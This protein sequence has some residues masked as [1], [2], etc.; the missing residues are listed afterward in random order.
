MADQPGTGQPA[1][2]PADVTRAFSSI[3]ERTHETLREWTARNAYHLTRMGFQ[4]PLSFTNA[5]F[6]VTASMIVDPTTVVRAHMSLWRDYMG[7]WQQTAS[8]LMGYDPEA[9]DATDTVDRRFRDDVWKDNEIFL[10]VKQSYLLAARWLLRIIR[11]VDG[12]DEAT[13]QRAD[14]YAR[15][16]VNA[17]SPSRFVL[18][19]P[20][21]IRA[22]IDSGGENLL[23]SLRHVLDDLERSASIGLRFDVSRGNR[24]GVDI[25]ASAGAVVLRTPVME[26]IQ[27][28]ARTPRV[29]GRPLLF[30][31]P[32]IHK[33]YVIDLR[34]E[35]SWI[36]WAVDQG[37][38]V[39]VISWVNPDAGRAGLTF[40]DYLRDGA[41][42]AFDAVA[43][44]TGQSAINVIGYCLGGTL[45]ATAAAVRSSGRKARVASLSLLA[46]LTDYAEPGELGVF[47]DEAT[48]RYFET[49]AEAGHCVDEHEA[50]A[51]YKMLRATDLIWSFIFNNYIFGHDAF[52]DDLLAWN[53]DATRIPA[54]LHADYLCQFYQRN[55]LALP[56]GLNVADQ[57]I[58][59]ADIR[60]PIYLLA[61]RE[62]H[63]APW[64]SVYK[65]AAHVSAPTRFVLAGSGHVTGV[66]NTP[67]CNKYRYWTNPDTPSDPDAWLD[68]A[69]PKQGS[70][71][72]DWDL[73]VRKAGGAARV[74]ARVPGDGHLPALERAPGSYV[75]GR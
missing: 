14:L 56:G 1:F 7:L 75:V 65:T 58:D 26:L 15:E 46:T 47:V 54:A 11:D 12:L 22:T 16:F 29:L 8:R 73:W 28:E 35:T 41:L 59:L 49:R 10:F 13:A 39:F 61:A 17:L 52:P 2:D 20:E 24:L 74:K 51:T 23:A 72:A 42:A 30:I 36:R 62:D 27:Y 63:L 37:H 68:A 45:A 60:A 32:W 66:I 55:R 3:A 25:A 57:T 33:Y 38:T 18:A 21:M 19:N 48:I 6:G 44:A 70:W 69:E 43:K 71:W 64:R 9:S 34:P 67:P 53:A 40:D 50:Q 31:P 5:F 4:D